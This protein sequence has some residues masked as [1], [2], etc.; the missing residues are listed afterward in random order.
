M[1]EQDDWQVLLNDTI[2]KRPLRIERNAED[3][4]Y[5]V[6]ARQDRH[7]EG[8][9]YQEGDDYVHVSP[10]SIDEKVEG[11]ASTRHALRRTLK[12]LHFSGEAVD[13]VMQRIDHG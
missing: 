8:I 4:F 11:E 5:R 12:E 9:A 13:R 2:E 1:S 10:S 6:L 3:G 7:D